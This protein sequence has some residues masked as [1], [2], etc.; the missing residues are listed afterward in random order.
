MRTAAAELNEQGVNVA[1]THLRYINPLPRNFEE[2]M[3]KYKRVIVAELNTG[4]LADYLQSIHPAS[5]IFR[6]N[7]IQGQPFM[8]SEL[9]S[10]V[11]EILK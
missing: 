5:E 8:V 1:F 6:I 10:K 2:I 4:M 9:V 7:K 11:K 3:S